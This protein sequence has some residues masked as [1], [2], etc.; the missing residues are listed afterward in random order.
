MIGLGRGRWCNP[1][2]LALWGRR[3]S[4]GDRRDRNRQRL[5]DKVRRPWVEA[6]QE[7][8]DVVLGRLCADAGPRASVGS[9]TPAVDFADRGRLR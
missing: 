7:P 6:E 4:S 3:L 9:I 2:S 5:G 8:D 1:Q